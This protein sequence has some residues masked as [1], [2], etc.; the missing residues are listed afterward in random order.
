M[1]AEGERY[2]PAGGGISLPGF[3]RFLAWIAVS[4]AV[5]WLFQ[6]VVGT[7]LGGPVARPLGWLL[8]SCVWLFFGIKLIIQPQEHEGELLAPRQ[9]F[10][11]RF[12]LGAVALGCLVV[13]AFEFRQVM[14]AAHLY[15]ASFP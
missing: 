15:P 5:A 14:I 9:A 2:Q 3:L 7:W 11:A 6:R 13:A 4:F 12:Q 1:S 10:V 8:L